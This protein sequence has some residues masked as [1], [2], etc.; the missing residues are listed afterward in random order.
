MINGLIHLLILSI[1]ITQYI[2]T[3]CC[4]AFAAVA[5][6]EGINQIVTG[7]LVPLSVQQI[8]DCYSKSCDRGYIDDALKYIRRNGGIDSDVD[9]PYNATYEQCDK[10]KV[11]TF[12]TFHH[13]KMH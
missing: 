6:V 12:H 9:Y 5:T 1:L 8:V 11:N 13:F 2:C 10:K 4:W 3:V 7:E